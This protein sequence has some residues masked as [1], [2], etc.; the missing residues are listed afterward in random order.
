[1]EQTSHFFSLG[2]NNILIEALKKQGIW[3]PTQVQKEAIPVML[4][5]KD[6]IARSET[7]SGKTLAYLLPLFMGIDESLRATQAIIIT[8]THELA[9][10]VHKQ[11]TV[12]AEN[13]SMNIRSGLMI[14]GA[15]MARQIEKLKKEKPQIITGSAGRILDL[16]QKKKI[17][18]HTVK[19]IVIDEADRMLDALNID[20]L[21]AV[22]KTTLKERQLCFFSASMGMAAV[23]AAK[24]LMKA[25]F[26]LLEGKDNTPLPKGIK[27]VYIKCERREKIAYIRKLI[28]GLKAEKTIVFIN[29]PENIEVTVEKL[30]FHELKA[31]GL[32]GAIHKEERK[33][34]LEQ[35]RSGKVQVLVASDIGARGLDVPD[36]ALVIQLDIP[37]D[38]TLYLHRAGRTGRSGKNGLVVSL[39]TAYEE[40]FVRRYSNVYHIEISQ[41]DMSYG[42]LIDKM[43]TQ[44]TKGKTDK[45]TIHTK[46]ITGRKTTGQSSSQTG[47]KARREPVSGFS[48]NKKQTKGNPVPHRTR[49]KFPR[50]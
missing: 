45:P 9:A 36:V 33:T 29:N 28:H 30:C 37:E 39:A 23:E 38:P 8:P 16:I 46:E 3:E 20:T 48:Q 24:E 7:G 21:K 18:A 2:I 26:I 41:Q 11:V 6:F 14:G 32:Y 47:Q 15:N 43:E 22:I 31:A 44:E 12:L 4:E 35:F 50:S 10:Q 17:S 13:S 5:K 49:D 42:R 27:H 25:D 1:M 19:T 40:R 34:A